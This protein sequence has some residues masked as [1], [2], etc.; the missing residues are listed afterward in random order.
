[1][2]D[3]AARQQPQSVLSATGN[4]TGTAAAGPTPTART[5]SS[6]SVMLLVGSTA[7]ILG[8]VSLAFATTKPNRRRSTR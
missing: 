4:A 1:M 8:A 5:G 6:A 7:L 2:A 3:V